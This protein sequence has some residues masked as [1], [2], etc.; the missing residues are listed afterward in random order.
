MKTFTQIFLSSAIALASV[1]PALAYDDQ[2]QKITREQANAF[3][4]RVR[5]GD[6]VGT[7]CEPCGEAPDGA[8]RI[9][10]AEVYDISVADNGDYVEIY[11]NDEVIDLAY[12][13]IVVAQ[14]AKH[15][16]LKNAAQLIGCPSSGVT[17]RLTVLKTWH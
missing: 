13:Y 5:H 8:G 2:C 4:A 6:M 14:T 3:T 11:L 16:R 10:M 17:D 9:P 1:T 12:T 15:W 7:L